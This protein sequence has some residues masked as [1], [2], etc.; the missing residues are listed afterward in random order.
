MRLGCVTA[1][2]AEQ[3]SPDLKSFPAPKRV[4]IPRLHGPIKIDG[5]LNEPTWAE[6]ARLAER[7]LRAG[8]MATAI[9]P[10]SGRNVTIVRI[11][12]VVTIRPDRPG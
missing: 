6:A 5:E 7:A 11:G 9:A 1:L 4:L 3:K 10:T 2:P 12:K 8:A